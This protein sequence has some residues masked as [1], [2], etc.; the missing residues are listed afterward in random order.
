MTDIIVQIMVEVL[1]VLAI[2][3]K[4]MKHGRMSELV[5]C[6]SIHLLI[7]V[8]SEKY[9]KKLIGNRDVEDSLQRLDK[10]TQEE[11]RMASAE[12]LKITHG[13]EDT[14]QDVDDKLDQVNRSSSPSLTTPHS[15]ALLSSQGIS[16]EIIFY[17]GFPLQTPQSI[18]IL[19]R[20][21]ITTA[22]PSGSFEAVYIRTGNPLAPFCGCTENVRSSQLLLCDNS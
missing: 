17:D 3:T 18:I 12:L 21:L 10:L 20:K 1:T 5:L 13:V 14:I 16:S 4:E 22:Q 7:Q 15:E 6:R 9:L 2:A 11:A 19:H 8:Y